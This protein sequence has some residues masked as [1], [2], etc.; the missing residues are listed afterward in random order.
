MNPIQILVY[1]TLC[2]LTACASSPQTRIDED[3]ALFNSYSAHQ[4]YLIR[5]GKIEVGFDQN[6]V[7]LAWGNPQRT[8]EDTSTKGTQLIWEYTVLQP[9]LGAFSSA[10][11][12][13][14]IDV[15][16]HA[17]GSP[18]K[19]NLRGRVFFNPQTGKVAR[20]QAFQ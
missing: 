6:Q 19:T 13:R 10:T 9:R 12:K 7:R 11:I 16:V 3:Q 15:G 5:T 18:T 20:F 2:L 4:Q 17:H 14:G 8:R 1:I